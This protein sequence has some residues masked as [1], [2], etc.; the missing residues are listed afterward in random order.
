MS[1]H[2]EVEVKVTINVARSEEEAGRQA[3]GEDVTLIEDEGIVLQTFN[4]DEEEDGGGDDDGDG[5]QDLPDAGAGD[6]PET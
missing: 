3:R 2:P 1:L 4:P 6:Q 5:M